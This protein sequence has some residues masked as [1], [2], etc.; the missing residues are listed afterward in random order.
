MN[1]F[2]VVWIFNTIMFFLNMYESLY[3]TKLT[4]NYLTNFFYI[5]MRYNHITNYYL[6]FNITFLLI[7]I[8]VFTYFVHNKP[9]YVSIGSIKIDYEEPTGIFTTRRYFF[10][11]FI[12]LLLIYKFYPTILSIFVSYLLYYMVGIVLSAF[13]IIYFIGNLKFD[14]RYFTFNKF[15]YLVDMYLLFIESW[16]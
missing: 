15:Y 16:F 1:Y 3:L 7:F 11:L 6:L 5:I 8:F 2:V 14:K 4:T 13:V 9:A 12:L 10:T